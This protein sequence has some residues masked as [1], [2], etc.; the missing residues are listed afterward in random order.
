MRPVTRKRA[1]LSFPTC[2]H[3][4]QGIDSF[5]A[6]LTLGSVDSQEKVSL[7]TSLNWPDLGASEFFGKAFG[8]SD[9]DAT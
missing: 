4:V 6:C 3:R 7:K 5:I 8:L 1:S 9:P 2:E